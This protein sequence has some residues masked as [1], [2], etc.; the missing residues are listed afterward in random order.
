MNII[1]KILTGTCASLFYGKNGVVA[2]DN[3]NRDFEI[4]NG[5]ALASMAE[6]GKSEK[7]V[8]ASIM[9]QPQKTVVMLKDAVELEQD[10]VKYVQATFSV[11]RNEGILPFA[12]KVK[13][14]GNITGIYVLPTEET[15]GD[16]Q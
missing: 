10:G 14:S 2:E 15:I 9:S 3:L 6:V 16:A 13:K 12:P 1:E 7:M 4:S 8:G 11:V 5:I